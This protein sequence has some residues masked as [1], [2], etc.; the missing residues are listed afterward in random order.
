MMYLSFLLGELGSFKTSVGSHSR[1]SANRRRYNSGNIPIL[2]HA[3]GYSLY[4][5]WKWKRRLLYDKAR[6]GDKST[7]IHSTTWQSH[8]DHPYSML[9]VRDEIDTYS[10]SRKKSITNICKTIRHPVLILMN[11]I[12][13]VAFYNVNDGWFV[14]SWSRL[15]RIHFD[16]WSAWNSITQKRKSDSS[17]NITPHIT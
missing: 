10:E 9:S 12:I 1:D 13:L 7:K 6:V 11:A 15:L 14:R 4:E 5:L 16:R 17:T 3:A 2:D 8:Q